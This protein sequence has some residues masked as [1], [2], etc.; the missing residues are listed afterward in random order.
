MPDEMPN[1]ASSPNRYFAFPI[2]LLSGGV[3]GTM[4]CFMIPR[5][6][7]TINGWLLLA[8]W[9]VLSGLWTAYFPTPRAKAYFIAGSIL[10]LLV[11]L[12]GLALLILMM[13]PLPGAPG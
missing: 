2:G 7:A 4:G 8:A 10:G 3:M 9:V 13:P 11:P 6:G 5:T 1:P 12:G